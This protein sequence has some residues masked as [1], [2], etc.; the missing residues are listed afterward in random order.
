MYKRQLTKRFGKDNAVD[1]MPVNIPNGAVVGLVDSNGS[2][3]STLLRMLA[4]VYAPDGGTVKVDGIQHFD[5]PAVSY[6]HLRAP[7]CQG[8]GSGFEPR[9]PLQ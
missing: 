4:G 1:N 2:G 8:G 5:N 9:H 7:P 6:T 3:K